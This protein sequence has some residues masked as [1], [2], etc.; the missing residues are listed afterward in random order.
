MVFLQN[1]FQNNKPF[2]R[3]FIQIAQT[4]ALKVLQ[5]STNVP[6]GETWDN[7]QAFT[8]PFPQGSTIKL[9]KHVLQNRNEQ[10]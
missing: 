10:V 4:V 1:T 5:S 3:L 2:P 7:L 8:L 9:D 6:W